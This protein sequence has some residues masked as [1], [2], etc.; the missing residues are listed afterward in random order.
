[1]N[2]GGI[3]IFYE[4]KN[5]KVKVGRTNMDYVTFG[6]GQKTLVILPGLGDGLR[7]V[8]GTKI[9]LARM[10]KLFA[11]EY[12]VYVFSRK[13]HIEESYSTRDM[14]KDQKIAMENL[15][16]ENAYIMGVSQGGMISQYLAIDYPK[17]VSKLIIAILLSTA[18]IIRTA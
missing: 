8:K 15:G 13:N 16:I 10:Y 5:G 7:T 17:M 11:K 6:R 2:E 14:A 18:C 1:M 4:A 9:L 3:T 12:K